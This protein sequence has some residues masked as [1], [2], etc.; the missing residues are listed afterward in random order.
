M[1]DS[2][3]GLGHRL[4]ALLMLACLSPLCAAEESSPPSVAA[5]AEPSTAAAQPPLEALEPAPVDFTVVGGL[6]IEAGEFAAAERTLSEGLTALE[7]SVPRYDMALV[8]PLLLLGDAQFGAEEYEAAE[9]TYGRAVH[10]TRVNEGLHSPDQVPAVYREAEALAAQGGDKI[11]A[12]NARQEYAYETLR[13]NYGP[14][15]EALVPGMYALAAW[16]K[17]THNIYSARDLYAQAVDALAR[18]HGDDSP[19]LVLPLRGIAETYRQERFPPY[20]APGKKET[21]TISST[22][23][24]PPTIYPENIRV[25]QINR[26]SDGERALGRIIKILNDD[27]ETPRLDVVLAVLDLADWHMLFEKYDRA[28]ELYARVQSLLATDGKLEPA[29]IGRYF[30]QPM[31]LYLPMPTPPEPPPSALRDRRREGFVELGYAVTDQG[32]VV[33]LEVLGS[34]P[35]GFM[36]TKVRKAMEIARFRPRFA[37]G[38]PVATQHLKYRHRFVYYPGREDADQPAKEAAQE[39]AREDT[40]AEAQNEPQAEPTLETPAPTQ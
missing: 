29:A 39:D 1:N 3:I 23:G 30:D 28:F 12:A 10:V 40:K 13:R 15:S 4:A 18:V 2:A 22:T 17:R 20:I 38:A 6:Q 25:R 16:Y 36:D 24:G 7:A 35:Q 19:E 21:V 5:P 11:N 9:E 27:P 32:G 31:P 37:D 8:K 26:Y 14:T 33:K 34:D